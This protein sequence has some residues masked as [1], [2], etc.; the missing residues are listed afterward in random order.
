VTYLSDILSGPAG[1]ALFACWLAIE[2]RGA[3]MWAW[4]GVTPTGGCTTRRESVIFALVTLIV[5]GFGV[6][7]TRLLA[8]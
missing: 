7:I 5:G 3:R 1:W 2:W 4:L 6:W 8:G